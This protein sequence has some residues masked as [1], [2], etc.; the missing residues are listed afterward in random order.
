MRIAAIPGTASGATVVAADADENETTTNTT[1]NNATC[2]ARE[3]RRVERTNIIFLPVSGLERGLG[4]E[5]LSS[6]HAAFDPVSAEQ[7]RSSSLSRVTEQLRSLYAQR[8]P[9]AS[10]G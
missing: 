6:P 1:T 3:T 9:A 7:R 5:L 4:P 10:P 2:T 8:R